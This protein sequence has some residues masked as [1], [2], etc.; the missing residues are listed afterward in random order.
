MA[1]IR[2]ARILIFDPSFD[3]ALYPRQIHALGP[4]A[5]LRDY[6]ILSVINVKS[7]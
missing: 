6:G 5:F 2:D 3:G 7:G 1:V 4:N